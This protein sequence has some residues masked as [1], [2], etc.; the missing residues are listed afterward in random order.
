MLTGRKN[1]FHFLSRCSRSGNYLELWT[2]KIQSTNPPTVKK[3][4]F[5]LTCCLLAVFIVLACNKKITSP[6]TTNTGVQNNQDALAKDYL[7][8]ISC[9]GFRWDYVQRFQPPNLKKFIA[10]GVE[11]E[12]LVPC[13]PSK[14]FPNH[15]SIATG[16]YPDHHGLVDNSYFDPVKND[17][18]QIGDRDKV[19]DG[20]WYDGTPIWV[21][22]ARSGMVTASY[23]FVGSEADVQGVRPSYYHRYDGSVPNDQ[24]VQAVLD[25]LKLPE[26]QRPHL[27]TLYFSDMDDTGHRFGPDA[28]EKLRESLLNLDQSL[29]KLFDGVKASGLPVNMII[30]SDHGMAAVPVSQLIPLEKLENDERYR[31]VNNGALVHFYFKDSVDNVTTYN[32][33][34][35]IEDHFSIFRTQEVPYFETF[36]DNLRWGDLMAVPEKGWY[37]AN[38]RTIGLRKIAGQDTIGEHGYHPKERDMHGIFYANGPAFR[39]GLFIGSIK[40]IHVYPLMC[41]VL[42]LELPEGVDGDGDVLKGVLSSSD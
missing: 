41:G 30:V 15:Y 2:L 3:Q 38:Q 16:M 13:F 11:A 18:Y 32:D 29:G 27:I 5:R 33:L 28:D 10:D 42:G 4:I 22:A 36:P 6:S 24:R 31:T 39:K 37:F 20:T 26:K 12:S 19:E 35:A 7:I 14:T 34:K 25:W 17:E 8:L 1:C 9:D 21:Q 23:F 40:N